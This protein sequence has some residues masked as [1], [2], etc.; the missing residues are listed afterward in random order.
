MKHIQH[1]KISNLYLFYSAPIVT[2][3]V[4][5]AGTHMKGVWHLTEK[6]SWADIWLAEIEHSSLKK[7]L[8]F[9]S[10][11]VPIYV[12][13]SFYRALKLKYPLDVG[14]VSRDGQFTTELILNPKDFHTVVDSE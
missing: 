9:Y 8:S 11:W 7:A 1:K 10:G 4:H 5:S 14:G 6:A 2:T 13:P 12:Y 3:F